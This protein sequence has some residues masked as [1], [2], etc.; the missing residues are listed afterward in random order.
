MGM[1]G[2]MNQELQA[3]KD[4]MWDDGL[5]AITT[6]DRHSFDDMAFGCLLGAFAADSCGSYLEFTEETASSQDMYMAMMMPG[7]GPHSVAAGQITD[8]SEMAM[9]LLTGIVEEND[10]DEIAPNAN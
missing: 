1:G 2:S 7:G 9:S 3:Q 4:K 5:A 10:K 8:D 6:N